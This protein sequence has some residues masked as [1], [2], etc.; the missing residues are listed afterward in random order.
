MAFDKKTIFILIY[1]IHF[2]DR[3][4]INFEDR[5]KLRFSIRV[6]PE[7]YFKNNNFVTG[8]CVTENAIYI[9]KSPYMNV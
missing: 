5:N 6:N 2:D 3:F 7:L 4:E 8:H 1:A 9:R